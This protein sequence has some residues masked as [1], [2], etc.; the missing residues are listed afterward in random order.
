[1]IRGC[2]GQC[3]V[4][5][6]HGHYTKTEAACPCELRVRCPNAAVCN[7]NPV[8]R[9]RSGYC[10]QCTTA[11]SCTKVVQ[12]GVGGCPVCLST[13]AALCRVP[14]GCGHGVCVECFRQMYL[15][16]NLPTGS[17]TD[18]ADAVVAWFEDRPVN[19]EKL[20]CPLCRAT[21]DP[22]KRL[23]RM[24]EGSMCSPTEITSI[25]NLPSRIMAVNLIKQ[26]PAAQ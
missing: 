7:A 5:D 14:S 16:P 22:V 19:W 9:W 20:M 13:S 1:M 24:V 15:G 17:G 18:Y 11:L 8:P 25:S 21:P 26:V 12:M 10:Y 4:E 2:N 3:F 23:N 6:R